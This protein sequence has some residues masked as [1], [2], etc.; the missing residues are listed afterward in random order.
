MGILACILET[1]V[2]QKGAACDPREVA[3]QATLASSGK[4]AAI[5]RSR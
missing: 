1:L 4:Y 2:V 3:L 5:T